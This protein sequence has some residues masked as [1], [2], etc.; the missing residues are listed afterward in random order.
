VLVVASF[1]YAAVQVCLISFLVVYLAE[2][3]GFAL[4]L[5]GYA[6][7]AANLGGIVGRIGWGALADHLA[8]PRRLFGVLGLLSASLALAT[9]AFTPGWPVAMLIVVC[10]CFGATAIGWN[11]VYLGEIARHSPPGQ[12]GAITGACGFVTFGG[13]VA[14]PPLFALL[15]AIT[16]SY[17]PGFV[18]CAFCVGTIG[19]YLVVSSMKPSTDFGGKPARR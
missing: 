12:A 14:G 15:T 3:L 17:R 19:T 9:A 7:T 16:G 18:A 1:I 2:T 13:V 10:T 6:L 8:Q 11:G 5:A 4:T